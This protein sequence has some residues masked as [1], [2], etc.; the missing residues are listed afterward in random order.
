MADRN[1][2]PTEI[3]GKNRVIYSGAFKPNG[4]SAVANSSNKG[5][6][7]TVAR[8]STGLFTV[9]I[10]SVL[11][12]IDSVVASLQLATADDKYVNVGTI[13]VASKTFILHVWDISGGAVADVAANANNW[14]NFTLIGRASG[15][16]N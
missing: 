8:T 14:I 11:G 2:D 3:I 15:A 13:V 16:E 7:W 6:G 12:Q 10:N 4:S 1:F 5:K 9:T